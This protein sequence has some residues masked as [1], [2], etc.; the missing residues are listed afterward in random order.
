MFSL[1]AR[2]FANYPLVTWGLVGATAYVFK[3]GAVASYQQR[4]FADEEAQRRLELSR[5]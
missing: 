1:L 3:A 4:L 5:V 2:S